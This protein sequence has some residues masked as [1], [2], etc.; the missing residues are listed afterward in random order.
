MRDPLTI[1]NVTGDDARAVK[2]RLG[3][4]KLELFG[5]SAGRGEATAQMDVDFKGE[6]TDIAF[7]PDYVLDGLKKCETQLVKLEF[8]ERTSP[9]KFTLGENYVYIVMPITVDA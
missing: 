1:A 8:D 7:N 6:E 2:F 5:Q 4:S 3:S 9:G